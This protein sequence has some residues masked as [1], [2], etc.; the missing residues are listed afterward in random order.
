M[1]TQFA[2]RRLPFVAALLSSLLL[3]L[4]FPP[5][6]SADAAFFALVPLLV[7]L[8]AA[9]S[10]RRGFALGYAFGLAFRLGDLSWLL[11]LRNNG[12]PVALVVLGLIGLSA[13]AALYTGLFGLAVASLWKFARRDDIPAP[14]LFRSGAWLAEP[15]LW[16]GGEHLVGSVLSGFPWNPLA[17][18]QYKN[19]ALLSC[20]SVFGT[21]TLSALLVAVNA[22]IASLALRIWDDALAPRFAAFAGGTRTGVARR[23][24]KVPRSLP[25]FLALLAVIAVWWNGMTEVRRTDLAAAAAPKFRLSVV[26]PDLP[27]IFERAGLSVDDACETLLSYTEL[28]GSTGPDATVW[29]ETVLPGFIPYDKDAARLIQEACTR[30]GAPLVSG[31]VEFVPLPGGGRDD[32]LIYNVAFHFV[33]GPAIANRYRKRHL[34]PFGEFIPLES[35]IPALKRLAPTGFSCEAGDECVLFE[36]AGRAA[37]SNGVVIAVAPLVCFEDV[38]PY[39]ARDAAANGADALVSLA[40]DAWFDGS[41]EAEQHLA[42]SVLRAVETGLPVIRSTNRG[43]SAF[44]LPNGRILRRLGDGRGSGTPGF[45]VDD[46]GIPPRRGREGTF[47]VRHGDALLGTP[48]SG[49]LLGIALAVWIVRRARARQGRLA[50]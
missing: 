12:G 9:G 34:V 7:A 15:L 22:G 39:L 2:R 38:F 44:I 30:T 10:P 14:W 21:A 19:L 3:G 25:L 20:L 4:A 35:K 33:E 17:A 13:Y 8:R 45:I 49:L 28:A 36:I 5:V 18:T 47:Y 27:S 41:A 23:R 50:P 32:G 11:A 16:V 42:Q 29:P 24:S 48:C 6:G 31:G 40:N 26:H 1:Y 43:V 46:F 37:A